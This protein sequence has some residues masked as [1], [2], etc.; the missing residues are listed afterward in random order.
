MLVANAI[1][2]SAPSAIAVSF[3]GNSRKRNPN[4]AIESIESLRREGRVHFQVVFKCG[5]TFE[6]DFLYIPSLLS[7]FSL[8][9]EMRK[10]PRITLK[11]RWPSP[12]AE[13]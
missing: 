13:G 4:L 9:P 1:V 3:K 5:L 11:R 6:F 2:W 12:W 8:A 10:Q 7:T